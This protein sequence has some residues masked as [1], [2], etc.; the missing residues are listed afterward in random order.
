MLKIIA[1]CAASAAI[2]SATVP[3]VIPGSSERGEKLFAEQ[4]CIQCHGVNGQG[5]KTAPD[6]GKKVDRGFTPASLAITMWNHAPV[7]WATMQAS[8]IEKPKLTPRDSADL[9]A[10]FYSTRYFDKP[11]DAARGRETFAAHHCAECHGIKDSLFAGAPPVA[12]WES[13]GHPIVLVQQMWNHS[14]HMREAFA[15]RKIAW[16]Q[17]TT[18]EL[19][20]ML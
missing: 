12:R 10:F 9:F 20:D 7:M 18:A 11:G 8:G 15:R 14:A 3:P 1:L 6:L 4:R 19:N 17:L 5:G 13:L 2:A 16:Q